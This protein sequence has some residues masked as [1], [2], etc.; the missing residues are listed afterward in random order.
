MILSGL[1]WFVNWF[2]AGT[3]GPLQVKYGDEVMNI[4]GVVKLPP[5]IL[6]RKN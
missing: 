5:S 2:G 3:L 6:E 4:L 1:Y